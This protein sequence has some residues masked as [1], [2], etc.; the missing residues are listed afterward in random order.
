MFPCNAQLCRWRIKPSNLCQYCEVYDDMEHYFVTCQ[1]VE[2]FWKLFE[3]WWEFVHDHSCQLTLNTLDILLGTMDATHA[4]DALN[5]CIL[6]AKWYI[7]RCKYLEE[8]IFFFNYLSELKNRLVIEKYIAS[9]NKQW[10]KFEKKWS[11]IVES[12]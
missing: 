2:Y 7:F 11:H 6:L 4:S 9:Q 8:D 5:F 10:V 3:R 1:K 12:L